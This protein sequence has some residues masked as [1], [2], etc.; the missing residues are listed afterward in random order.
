M[1]VYTVA[2]WWEGLVMSNILY[3]LIL[4]S[5]TKISQTNLK[6]FMSF[7]QK[8]VLDISAWHQH[9]APFTFC[10][11]FWI[12]NHTR[13]FQSNSNSEAWVGTEH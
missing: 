11:Y 7:Y 4:Q 10:L 8:A 1:N 13:D 5:V 2:A 6:R 3:N 12:S 9:T